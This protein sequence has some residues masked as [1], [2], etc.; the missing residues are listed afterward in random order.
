MYRRAVHTIWCIVLL[1][2]LVGCFPLSYRNDPTRLPMAELSPPFDR[3][4]FI[5]YIDTVAVD[6][7]EGVWLL[8]GPD[9]HYYLAIERINNMTYD[10]YYS[11]RIRLWNSVNPYLEFIYP[12]GQVIGYLGQGLY[13]NTKTMVLFSGLYLKSNL[14]K[15]T[16]KIDKT[17]KYIYIDRG[18]KILDAIGLRRIYPI[19]SAEEDEYR[20]RYL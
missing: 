12:H 1:L 2:L 15:K 8:T 14:F 19:R 4:Q 7:W 18:D 16:V 9:L 20:V 10:A 3:E 17:R 11:H 13:E 5:A 6:D